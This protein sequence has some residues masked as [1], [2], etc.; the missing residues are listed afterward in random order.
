MDEEPTD[1]IQYTDVELLTMDYADLKSAKSN[2]FFIYYEA[3]T[4]SMLF[5]EWDVA[6]NKYKF[7]M[8][9]EAAVELHIQDSDFE[10]II[11]EIKVAN[12]T[13][14]KWSSI[15]NKNFS[16]TKPEDRIKRILQKDSKFNWREPESVSQEQSGEK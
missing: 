9:H 3:F 14:K 10:R 2:S 5:T 16:I 6:E 7:N 15:P 13:I 1:S 11:R 12:D 4:I 8:Y